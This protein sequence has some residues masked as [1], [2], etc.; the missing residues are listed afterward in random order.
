MKKRSENSFK[1]KKVKGLRKWAFFLMAIIVIPAFFFLLVEI[2]LRISGYGYPASFYLERT[3]NEQKVHIENDRFGWRFFPPAI[4]RRPLDTMV[5]AD[6]QEDEF[7]IVILGGSAAMGDPDPSY[8]F[9]RILETLLEAESPEKDISVYNAAMTGINSHVVREISGDINRIKPDLVIL[10][11]GNNEV[12]GPF[13]CGSIFGRFTSNLSAIRLRILLQETKWGQM[14][15]SILKG[16]KN[17]ETPEQWGG[18]TMF[19]RGRLRYNNPDLK[20]TYDHF[21]KNLEAII[22]NSED[23]GAEILLCT[24]AVNHFS[25]PPFASLHSEDISKEKIKAWRERYKSGLRNFENGDLE[26][27]SLNFKAALGIDDKYALLHY[28]IAET[29]QESGHLDDA[30]NHYYLAKELDALLFRADSSIN[31]VIRK[32][33]RENEDMLFVDADVNFSKL[34]KEEIADDEF[35]LDH[36]HLTFTGNYLLAFDMARKICNGVFGRENEGPLLSE[37]ETRLKLAYT[38]WDDY[39]I[40]KKMM[41]RMQRPPFTNQYNHETVI[42]QRKEFLEIKTIQLKEGGFEES[43]ETYRAVIKQNPDDWQL[44]ENYAVLLQELN[45]PDEEAIEWQKV[46]NLIP[47]H[48][49]RYAKLGEALARSGEYDKAILACTKALEHDPDNISAYNGLGIAWEGK[50]KIDTAMQYYRK[51]TSLNKNDTNSIFNRAR[52]LLEQERY[53][54]AEQEFRRLVKLSPRD[55]ESWFQIGIILARKGDS[56][57]AQEAFEKVVEIDPE[58]TESYYYLGMIYAGREET[59]KSIEMLKRSLEVRPDWPV[60]ENELAWIYAIHPDDSIRN[61]K[62]ALHWAQ[63]ATQHTRF[64]NASY[65]DTLAAAYAE[66]GR[67]EDAINTAKKALQLISDKDSSLASEIEQRLQAYQSKIE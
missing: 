30:E 51:A 34:R 35:F 17:S 66:C 29:L 45:H 48:P 55:G 33:A 24:V 27:A 19:L 3:C 2:I 9:G 32:V 36:V 40:R 8:G 49:E 47:H 43:V 37:Q 25:C 62:K 26:S 12:V 58:H 18:M 64:K 56:D 46:I 20:I 14:L 6:K 16:D 5:A 67:Y 10:Y 11:L 31:E 38:E 57:K 59:E 21:R 52:M 7:R 65:L 1:K 15:S 44:H 60:A 42:E 28:L 61:G 39:R 23:T 54:E 4:A 22:K 41:E 63:K 50:G 53:D 13:G